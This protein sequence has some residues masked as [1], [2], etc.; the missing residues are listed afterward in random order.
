MSR[1]RLIKK[2]LGVG[3]L[4]Y[5]LAVLASVHKCLRICDLCKEL[6]FGNQCANGLSGDSY[7][8]LEFNML[9]RQFLERIR[10]RE[11]NSVHNRC[12]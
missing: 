3:Y 9:C 11:D 8:C 1:L 7:N 12:S 2:C 4:L 6:A 10:H 5:A